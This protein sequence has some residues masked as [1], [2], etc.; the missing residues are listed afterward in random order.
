MKL[1]IHDA[2]YPGAPVM[3]LSSGLGGSGGYW[4]AQISALKTQ[5]QVITYDQRGTGE[6]QAELPADYTMAMMA[7]ELHHALAQQGV[8]RYAVIGHALGG[9]IGIQLAL[10]YPQSITALVIINGWL[11]LNAQTRRCFAIRE[12]LL[13]SGGPAAWNLAQ[14]LFLYPAQWLGEQQPRL[15]AEEAL[16]NAHFQG[17]ANLRARLSALKQADFTQTAGQITQPVLL[18]CARDDLLVPWHCSQML[19]ECLPT[20]HLSV[21]PW[22]AHACNVTASDTFNS[23]LLDGLALLLPDAAEERYKEMLCKKF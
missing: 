22:G 10:S 5:Y 8:T 14:P 11:S 2:P 19:H 17:E 1:H 4:V 7:D 12:Q 16:H 21:M 9:L 18:I 23:L 15:E 3:V 6:N 13:S 20:S